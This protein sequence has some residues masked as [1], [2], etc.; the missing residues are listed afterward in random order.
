MYIEQELLASVMVNT[1]QILT[2]SKEGDI[3]TNV[4]GCLISITALAI[5]EKN[6]V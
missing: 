1:L 6:R 2:Q 4:R 5:H 3:L